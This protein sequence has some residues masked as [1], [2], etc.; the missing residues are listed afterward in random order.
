MQLLSKA[1]FANS[2]EQIG[3]LKLMTRAFCDPK[4]I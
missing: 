3:D 1:T 2:D 4:D